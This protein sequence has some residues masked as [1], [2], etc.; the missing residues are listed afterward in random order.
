MITPLMLRSLD[1]VAWTT[2]Y[3][4][5]RPLEYDP[6]TGLF[7]SNYPL[8]NLPM[9]ILCSLMSVILV[10][11]PCLLVA[12]GVL[13]GHLKLSTLQHTSWII[14]L[15]YYTAA[16]LIDITLSLHNRLFTAAF[17]TLRNIIR[18]LQEGKRLFCICML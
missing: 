9:W 16:L 11:I 15:I 12:I 1:L 14:C 17:R 4:W 2:S 7:I 8:H 18:N 13:L 6:T 5:K 10:V 3:L